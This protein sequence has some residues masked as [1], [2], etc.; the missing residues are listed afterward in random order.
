MGE[1]HQAFEN[2]N[3]IADFGY[4]KGYKKTTSKKQAGDKSHFFGKFTTNFSDDSSANS[5][6]DIKM[7]NVSHDKYFKLYKVESNLVDYNINTLENSLDFSHEDDQ[8]FLRT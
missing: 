5:S 4:T 1:Y 3:L 6:L 2:S 8:I 7:Q